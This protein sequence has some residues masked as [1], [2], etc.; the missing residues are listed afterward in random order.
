VIVG[1]PV[2]LFDATLPADDLAKAVAQ[3]TK[4]I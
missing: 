3:K 2:Y 1:K 4:L